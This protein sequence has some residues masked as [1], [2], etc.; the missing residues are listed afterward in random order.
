M[1][2]GTKPKYNNERMINMN[3]SKKLTKGIAII[4][5]AGTL[6]GSSAV[7]AENAENVNS[8]D[9]RFSSDEIVPYSNYIKTGVTQISRGNGCFSVSVETTASLTATRIY[10]DVTIYKNGVL[11]S[12]KRYQDW[13]ISSLYTP[14]SVPASSGDPISVSTKHY[15]IY[16]GT[17]ESKTSSKSLKY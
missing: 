17:T 6:F 14:I 16:N 15:V 12:S 13:N 10:H 7:Y 3:L 2:R 1:Q 5:A 4:A 11:Y 9:I 8:I